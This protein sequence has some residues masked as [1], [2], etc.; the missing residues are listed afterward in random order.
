[1]ADAAPRR[2]RKANVECIVLCFSGDLEDGKKS[3]SSAV[4]EMFDERGN[5]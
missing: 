3:E 2:A 1:M 5:R 4:A